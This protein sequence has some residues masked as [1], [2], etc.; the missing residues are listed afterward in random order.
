MIWLIIIDTNNAIN[1][2]TKENT[3]INMQIAIDSLCFE[4]ILQF[5]LNKTKNLSTDKATRLN[6]VTSATLSRERCSKRLV[7]S[8]FDL[9]VTVAIFASIPKVIAANEILSK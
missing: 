1:I 6:T 4:L 8:L 2:N 3:H 5:V 9:L 7:I